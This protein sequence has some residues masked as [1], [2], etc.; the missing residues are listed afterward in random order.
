MVKVMG[1]CRYPK[2][3]ALHLESDYSV[4][5]EQLETPSVRSS[6]DDACYDMYHSRL[7]T[8]RPLLSIGTLAHH[9]R[10]MGRIEAPLRFA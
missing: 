1:H 2:R 5:Q 4:D 9:H 8:T 7:P 6:T 10:C 3:R